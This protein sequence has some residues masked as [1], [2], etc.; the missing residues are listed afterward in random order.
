VLT[1]WKT[2][3]RAGYANRAGLTHLAWEPLKV[4]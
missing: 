4:S 1:V 3:P 2:I